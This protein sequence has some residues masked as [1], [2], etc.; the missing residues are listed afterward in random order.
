[1]KCLLKLPLSWLRTERLILKWSIAYLKRLS[2]SMKSDI[3]SREKTASQITFLL[4]TLKR[5]GDERRSEHSE[6]GYKC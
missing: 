2:S 1:M 5:A 3:W 4:L 6:M